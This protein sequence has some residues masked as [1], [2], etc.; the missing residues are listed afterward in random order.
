M[1]NMERT[2]FQK[3]VALLEQ[4]GAS[5]ELNY[6]KITAVIRGLSFCLTE[7]NPAYYYNESYLNDFAGVLVQAI[8]AIQTKQKIAWELCQKG[9]KRELNEARL[10][11]YVDEIWQITLPD[12]ELDVKTEGNLKGL[13]G[14]NCL[15][16][17]TF[18]F[19][20]N[21]C[22]EDLYSFGIG[23]SIEIMLNTIFEPY[24]RGR[25]KSSDRRDKVV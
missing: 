5:K 21:D 24:E 19:D 20:Q 9:A 7:L 3:R 23:E 8:E 15:I 1:G 4:L 12:K 10:T 18:C 11:I 22:I 25:S 13:I 17:A 2:Y 14:Q 6:E 16:R